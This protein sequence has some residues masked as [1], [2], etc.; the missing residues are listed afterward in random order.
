M[1]RRRFRRAGKNCTPASASFNADRGVF[2]NCGLPDADKPAVNYIRKA[3]EEADRSADG[4]K[5]DMALFYTLAAEIR[6]QYAIREGKRF[7]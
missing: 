6:R 4:G 1:E 2:C 7:E 5:Y 3:E